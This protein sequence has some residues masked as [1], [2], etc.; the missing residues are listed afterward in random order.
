MSYTPDFIR[1]LQRKITIDEQVPR[2]YAA[3][4]AENALYRFDERVQEGVA[5]WVK[6]DLTKD[7]TVEDISLE[8][9]QFEIGGSLFQALCVMDVYLKNNAF[10]PMASWFEK[11]DAIDVE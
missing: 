9:I 4:L 1:D 7:F 8:D 11:E 6:G 2:A 10:I 3:I 5:Q